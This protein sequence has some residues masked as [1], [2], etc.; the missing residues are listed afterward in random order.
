MGV[1]VRL[2]L[3]IAGPLNPG[4]ARTYKI[5]MGI[6]MSQSVTLTVPR[7][8]CEMIL[9]V[10]AVIAERFEVEALAGS[11][12]MGTV[13]RARDRRSGALVALKLLHPTG[14]ALHSERFAREARLLSE[15]SHPR[16]VSH[17]AH[18][19]TPDGQLFLA[20]EWLEG[21]DLAQ[22]LTCHE[23]MT[24]RQSVALARSVAEALT[25]AHRHGVVH[26][27][28]KPSNLFLRDGNLEHVTV[29][30]F[31]IARDVTQSSRLTRTNT[32]IGS[33]GYMAPEQARAE[34]SIRPSA[35]IFSLGCVLF[36]C[37]AGRPVFVGGHLVALLTKI[38]LE[39]APL[40]RSVRPSAP[41]SLEALVARMLAKEPTRRPQN[42]AA[43]LAELDGLELGPSRRDSA[44][45][46]ASA[47]PAVAASEQRLVSVILAS[48]HLGNAQV[49]LRRK[50]VREALSAHGC[51]VEELADGSLAVALV[52]ST[53]GAATDLAVQAARCAMRVQALWPEAQVTL[54]T[55]R[56]V[57]REQL[58]LGEAADRAGRLHQM[59]MADESLRKRDTDAVC[60]DDVTA[61]LVDAQ[62]EVRRRDDGSFLLGG[63][64]AGADETRLLLGKPTL[65]VG[66][67]Q[68]LASLDLM[69]A[70]CIER[71][72]AC[73]VVITAPPGVGKSRLRHEF[74]RRLRARGDIEILLGR[75]DPMS[76]GTSYG[77]LSQ[78]LRRLC[79]V[80]DGTEPAVQQARLIERTGRHVEA[81]AAHRIT[82]FLG[83]MC[84]VPFRD[85]DS[86]ELRAARGDPLQMSVQVTRAFTDFLRAECA[87]HTVLLV[88]ED[89][90]WGDALTARVIDA[91]LAEL[92]EQPLMV[93]ALAR[94][95]LAELL[96]RLWE[97]HE[98]QAFELR[99]LNRRA[100]E[101]LV[102]QVLGS[103]LT[104]AQMGRIVEQAAGN[105]L[106]LEEL[107]R[108]AAEGKLEELPGALM[109]MLQ[110]RLLRLNVGVRRVLLAASVFGET[111]WR[112][113]LL[114]LLGGAAEQEAI[115]RGLSALVA[116]EIVAFQSESRLAGEPEY[117]F[118]HALTR[119]AAYSLL[120]DDERVL[121][122]RAAGAYL[123][124]AGERDNLVLA[125]HYELGKD[126]ARAGHFFLRAA[127]QANR[128]GD[129]EAT[130]AHVHRGL[131]CD[132]SEDVRLR[133]LGLHDEGHAW[134]GDYRA[135]ST[136]SDELL[137]LAPPGSA[138]WW[139]GLGGKVCRVM[140]FGTPEEETDVLR[141][142][143]QAEQMEVTPETLE[144]SV[145]CWYAIV[146]MTL[147]RCRF[148]IAARALAHL[149]ALVN[150]SAANDPGLRGWRDLAHVVMGAEQSFAALRRARAAE[151]SLKEAG[152]LRGMQMA[153][154]L[155]GI[156]MRRLGRPVEAEQELRAT[157][158]TGFGPITAMRTACLIECIAERGALVKAE[159]E[160]VLFVESMV[161]KDSPADEGLARWVLSEVLLRKGDA[162]RAEAEARAGCALLT[163]V[164]LYLW[165][166]LIVVAAAQLAQGRAADALATARHV[167]DHGKAFSAFAPKAALV[168][169]VHAE[170]L[171][172][173]GEHTA[174]AAVLDD[175][176]RRLLEQ[177][178]QIDDPELR[179]SFLEGVPEHA[180]TLARRLWSEGCPS[181]VSFQEGRS[182]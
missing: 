25:A 83:E 65:C 102:Q 32:I 56:G 61:N 10:R 100:C 1:I 180:R 72:L 67:E 129:S 63:E 45:A 41:A 98:R 115:D 170:S 108:A 81:A 169:L 7:Q 146:G 138:V 36:E 141:L 171:H 27:D 105:A 142:V 28:I 29:L 97:Q 175:A 99:G 5:S 117:R 16:I 107:I 144:R 181:D 70:D 73:A 159:R 4:R 82:Q 136:Y 58:P 135:G 147:L 176:R 33:P 125:E 179:R 120:T 160:A 12:G 182:A 86:P 174:A 151:R 11:G 114:A 60:L 143:E 145:L 50:A 163:N 69:L 119:D 35:D 101:R 52:Q 80:V 62:L 85:D 8:P 109:A 9:P 103:Q 133:L 122:H 93:L 110:A 155:A 22:H 153:R 74:L 172:A 43:L 57:L 91:A 157:L 162:A 94:P 3:C 161:G 112:G 134:R 121:G 71:P 20:M 90:H 19:R 55:G 178:E 64:R 18:G 68:E 154:I 150:S 21:C 37:L 38:L 177:A 123:E 79:G 166:G 78:A 131:R 149:D 148:D 116:G 34:R 111:F 24:V 104:S 14:S 44:Q 46:E 6:T 173:L 26:R 164:T 95:E 75:G 140:V 127:Q 39:E 59:R 42:A 84:A 89:M 92:R 124:A 132:V 49:P 54:A 87:V 156:N 128:G 30:D 77:L 48:S 76:A 130:L 137:R 165:P 96:P 2:W 53:Q 139:I 66:R 158:D 88:L 168:R 118:R 17:V 31:G 23:E 51:Y 47:P 40:L 167:L 152:Y 113:G 126:T 13:F 106:Y 15:L